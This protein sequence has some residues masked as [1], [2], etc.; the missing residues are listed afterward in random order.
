MFKL[1]QNQLQKKST[2]RN[3]LKLW[4]ILDKDSLNETW[5]FLNAVCCNFTQSA[6]H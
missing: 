1:L 4:E 6:K 3:Y 5:S 2:V